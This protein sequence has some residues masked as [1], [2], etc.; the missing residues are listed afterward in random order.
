MKLF[1]LTITSLLFVLFNLNTGF[2]QGADCGSATSL[3]VN[4][5]CTTSSLSVSG[6]DSGIAAPACAGTINYDGWYSFTATG[7]STN[8]DLTGLNKDAAIAV[9][10]DCSGTLIGGTNCANAN[11]SG[12]DESLVVTTTPGSTYYVR[13]MRVNTG[14]G[15][16]TGN[17]CIYGAASTGPDCDYV[18]NMFDSYGD[19]WNGNSYEFFENGTSIGSYTFTT[20]SSSTANVSIADA[21]SVTIV[22]TTGSYT[23]EVSWEL[24]DPFGNLICSGGE[25]L[26]NGGTVCSFTANCSGPDEP[27]GAMSLGPQSSVCGSLTYSTYNNSG[28]SDS[29]IADPGCGNYNGGDMWFKAT[30]PVSGGFDVLTQSNGLN[31]M[32]MAVYSGTCSSLSLI[33]CSNNGNG[34]MP[35]ETVS[36]LSAG[37]EVFIRVWD[38]GGNST[39]TFNIVLDDPVPLYCLNGTATSAGGAN[40]VQLTSAST[41]QNGCAWSGSQFDFTQDFDTEF[42]VNLGSSDAGADGVAFVIQNTADGSSAACGTSGG[43][44]G[45]SG[46]TPSLIIEFDTWANGDRADSNVVGWE[47]AC[48]HISVET[49]GVLIEDGATN[50]APAFGPVQ[51]SASNCNIEDGADHIVRITYDAST[52]Q[53]TIFFDG[54]QRL[55][56]TFDLASFF[57]SNSAYW[58]FTASTGGAV[59]EQS[60]CPGTLPGTSL[61]TSGLELSAECK[62]DIPSLNWSA[63]EYFNVAYFEIEKSENGVEFNF[64]SLIPITNQ[65][66]VYEYYV[67]SLSSSENYFRI[68]S[69]DYNGSI[70]YSNVVQKQCLNSD[71]I[72]TIFAENDKATLHFNSNY[73]QNTK[74]RVLDIQGKIVYENTLISAK[75]YNTLEID[76][77]NISSHMYILNIIDEEAITSKKFFIR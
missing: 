3:T 62:N 27:C 64:H 60:F 51:A 55:Q 67:Y 15:S 38:E 72:I 56:F 2:S 26:T 24:Y 28:Y 1:K 45:A 74:V 6:S 18:F 34:N 50:S 69:V 21:S 35:T 58:G 42:T 77:L 40:C 37:D 39:G 29:G 76:L 68:K 5:S 44:I 7:S 36:G 70:E 48:D 20:G 52:N 8:I 71:A 30:V 13:V 25:P 10:S 4:A 54:S 14:G 47:P 75:G 19:G 32:A 49:D 43:G 66:D 65:T 63:N 61:G 46:I 59:N 9:Y 57:G 11:G 17:I 23:Y 22:V 31:D 41:A 12:G 33:S 53:I 73:S 16:M